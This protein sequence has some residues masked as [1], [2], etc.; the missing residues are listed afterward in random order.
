M[1]T[2]SRIVKCWFWLPALSPQG[3]TTELSPAA[4]A[5]LQETPGCAV[6]ARVAMWGSQH[7][8]VSTAA[9]AMPLATQHTQHQALLASF[10]ACAMQTGIHGIQPHLS[11]LWTLLWMYFPHTHMQTH[12]QSHTNPPDLLSSLGKTTNKPLISSYSCTVSSLT[13]LLG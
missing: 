11:L 3:Y 13:R 9:Q 6:C 10:S 1:A 2:C 12:G 4:L 7:W 8:T 5:S